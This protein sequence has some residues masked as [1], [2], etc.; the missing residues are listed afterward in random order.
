MLNIGC[1]FHPGFQQIAMFDQ[2]TGEITGRRVK[3]PE[4]AR[5][6]YAG[7]AEPARVGVE[8]CG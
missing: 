6:F 2:Q 8:A 1:D 3:H 7:L 4:E 5:G